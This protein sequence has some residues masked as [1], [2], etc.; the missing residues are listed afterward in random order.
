[1]FDEVIQS[2]RQWLYDISKKYDTIKVEIQ[3]DKSDVIIADIDNE[4]Y[5]AQIS[6]SEPDFRP[7]RFVEFLVLDVCGDVMQ[8]PAFVY[9]DT[10]E[11]S[12]SDIIENLNKGIDFIVLES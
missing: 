11:D 6:I 12:I 3:K 1:M 10:D 5:I 9:R 7:Y 4:R 8:S 2:V